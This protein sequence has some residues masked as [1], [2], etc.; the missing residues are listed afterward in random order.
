LKSIALGFPKGF[1][2][3]QTAGHFLHRF[4]N[5]YQYRNT[6]IMRR[7]AD[8]FFWIIFATER[9][10]K[11]NHINIAPSVSNDRGVVV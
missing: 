10:N 1:E 2:Y 11:N 8:E 6:N 4:V 5:T 7:V 3:Y 9:K